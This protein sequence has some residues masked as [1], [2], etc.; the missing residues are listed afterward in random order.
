MFEDPEFYGTP[1]DVARIT[2][3]FDIWFKS[4]KIGVT[5]QNRRLSAKKRVR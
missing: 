1:T 5:I 3:N 4:L 2:G